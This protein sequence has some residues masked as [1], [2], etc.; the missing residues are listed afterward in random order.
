MT[1]SV[2]RKLCAALAWFVIIG[3]YIVL[4]Q[5]GEHG[6]FGS[7]TITF[8]GYF[9]VLTN[10]LVALAFSV[11]F[12]KDGSGLRS[13]F[14]RPGVRTAIALYITVVA[15]VYYGVLAQNHHPQGISA[16][17]NIGLHFVLPCL[18][19]F[20]WAF[21]SNKDGL[22]FRSV[23]LWILYPF[24]YGLFNIVRGAITGFYPYPFLDIETL[25]FGAVAVNMLGFVL[26]YAIGGSAFIGVAKFLGRKRAAA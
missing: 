26:I 21:L 5:N 24:G 4:L 2:F 15:I 25:G 17:F 6:G 19:V 23:P 16:Y 11:P 1:T 8:F 3:Q 13:F 10:V 7:T 9:T 20:D 22:T 12:L 14:E 18:Y